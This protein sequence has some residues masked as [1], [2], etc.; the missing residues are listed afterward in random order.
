MNNR[1][2]QLVLVA[3]T[4]FL[5]SGCLKD[6]C[7]ATRTF[8]VDQPVFVTPKSFRIPVEVKQQR[9]LEDPGKIYYYQNYIFINELR[10]G[11][12]IYDN[13]KPTDP[14][15]VAFLAIPGNVDMAVKGNTLYADSYVDLLT[16]DIT[17]PLSAQMV[18]RRTDVFELWGQVPGQGYI[19]YYERTKETVDLDCDDANFGQ[20]IWFTNDNLRF[21]NV[22]V[23][24]DAGPSAEV[25]AGGNGVGGSLARFA[26]V[27]ELLYGIDQSTLR[28]FDI[29]VPSEVD[30]INDVG[31]GWGIETIFPYGENLFIGAN[32]GMYIFDN[33][34]PTRPQFLSKFQHAL[35]CDPVYVDGNL[36]Y[37]TLRDGTQCENFNNQLDVVDISNLSFPELLVTYP[38]H[39]PH[40]LSKAGSYL[41]ICEN[42][43]RR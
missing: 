4:T 5:F 24:F 20:D 1:L 12:H 11:I 3:V 27:D 16:I 10:E 42:D 13:T 15:P 17:N 38:M 37:V 25:S 35:A 30:K 14:Q 23:A 7:E 33:T 31:V 6:Q 22:D 26:I 28:I 34:N 2:V 36:A 43:H 18:D 19:G 9:A 21:V 39:N 32:D 41:Y 29:S 40:G 8:F